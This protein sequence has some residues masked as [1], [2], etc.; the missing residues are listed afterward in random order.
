MNFF[1]H[2]RIR[3]EKMFKRWF[4]SWLCFKYLRCVMCDEYDYVDKMQSAC[5]AEENVIFSMG[6][7]LSPFVWA[8]R[9]NVIIKRKEKRNSGETIATYELRIKEPKFSQSILHETQWN[10]HVY[11]CNG[12]FLALFIAIH[13]LPKAIEVCI[14][15]HSFSC[16]GLTIAN[17]F[18]DQDNWTALPYVRSSPRLSG[19][20]H[21]LYGGPK[22]N[23]NRK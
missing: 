19:C 1:K 10:S 4:R 9:T 15:T 3:L 22:W 14:R 7:F 2:L 13:Q 5:I 17:T 11:S 16:T 23:A 21:S 8:A 12:Y 18:C 6:N 20:F